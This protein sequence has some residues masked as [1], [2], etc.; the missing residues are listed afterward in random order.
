M[1]LSR[2]EHTGDAPATGL[3]AGIGTADTSFTVLSGTGYPTGAVGK[4]VVCLDAGTSSEEKILCLS[5]SGATFTVATSG[6][7]YDGTTASSHNS[8]TVNVTHVL[9]AAEIDDTSD[10]IYNTTRFDHDSQY[11]RRDGT[12]ALTGVA[13]VAATPGT[14]AVGD[15]AA[16]GTGPTLALSDH[17]HGRESFG[18]GQT[19]SVGVSNTDG[20]QATPARSDHVHSGAA[21][22]NT[23][24]G[25][26]GTNYTTSGAGGTF[27]TTA[28]L[29]VGTWLV[30]FTGVIGGGATASAT[31]QVFNGSATVTFT[32][33]TSGQAATPSSLDQSVSLSFLAT[34][35]GAGTLTFQASTVTQDVTFIA[36]GATGYV[37]IKVA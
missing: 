34:V 35:T 18:V 13:S 30:N 14:S 37:A 20:T 5:R 27:L 25:T 12:T 23:A 9:T 29:A 33:A 3:S 28:S 26:L 21:T 10:H 7:G 2:Y 11:L 19:K 32:G 8:G 6:R 17:K 31:Y 36:G 16:K 15:S 22:L 24:A 1:A 4:F